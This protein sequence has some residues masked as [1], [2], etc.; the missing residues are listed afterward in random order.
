MP[1]ISDH[2]HE[3]TWTSTV[4]YLEI[5]SVKEL[6]KHP[7]IA[8]DKLFLSTRSWIISCPFWRILETAENRAL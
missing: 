8:D 7:A 2:G 6:D 1:C 3:H 4:Q 5:Y